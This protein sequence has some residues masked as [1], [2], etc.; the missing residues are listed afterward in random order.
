[1]NSDETAS[2]QHGLLCFILERIVERSG[3]AERII[4]E[5]A[6]RLGESGRRVHIVTHEKFVGKPFYPLGRNVLHLNI[7]VPANQRSIPR[8][9]FDR[10]RDGLHAR[11]PYPPV[12][13]PAV[14]WSKHGGFILALEK[15]LELHRP[16]TVVA[17]APPAMVALAHAETS[18]SFRK[19][20][21][22]HNVPELDLT[23]NLRWD[24]NPLDIQ[25]RLDALS[26]FDAITVLQPSFRDWF[27]PTLAAKVKVVPNPVYPVT[28]SPF[29]HRARRIVCV[30]RLAAP[31]RVGLLIEAWSRIRE[32]FTGWRVEV[33]GSGHLED[34]LRRAIKQFGVEQSFFL[35]GHTQDVEEMYATASILAHPAEYEGWGLAVSE[36]LSRGIP[37]V[38]FR[39]CA[40]VNELIQHG[41][42]GLLVTD[43]EDLSGD[44]AQA[45]ASLMEDEAERRR[46]G[47][48]GPSSVTDFSPEKIQRRWEEVINGD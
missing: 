17:V 25:H 16:E 11:L 41:E 39:S 13:R 2:A 36:A 21:S 28:P 20:A 18:Y 26:K 1:M 33:Y 5:L 4:I 22:L 35:R 46:L 44:F 15:Y 8:R 45:L 38:A 42:N 27:E 7:R 10:F 40:G 3:G 23:S 14:W 34:E 32:R 37:A 19:I 48:H 24:R 12:A 31:K 30:G 6:N 29:E 43:G 47:G 9:V